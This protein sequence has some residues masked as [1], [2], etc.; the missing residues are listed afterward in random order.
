MT[1]EATVTKLSYLLGKGYKGKELEDRMRENL[2]GELSEK[3]KLEDLH[4]GTATKLRLQRENE[5][6]T[7]QHIEE[8]MYSDAE[9]SSEEESVE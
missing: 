3:P 4:Q 8:E 2:R 1:L 7:F 5:R 9:E 6:D